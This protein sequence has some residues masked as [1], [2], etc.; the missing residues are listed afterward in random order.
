MQSFVSPEGS[1]PIE[2]WRKTECDQQGGLAFARA[3]AAEDTSQCGAEQSSDF[4]AHGCASCHGLDG[5]GGVVGPNLL[6]ITPDKIAENVRFGPTGMPVFDDLELTEEHVT[7]IT[8]Y[9]RQVALANPGAVPTPVPPPP[10]PTATPVATP[11][12]AAVATPTTAPPA[13]PADSEILEEG[14]LIYQETAGQQGCAY[15]HGTDARGV[16]LATE[17]APDIRGASRSMIRTALGGTL[18]MSDIKLTSS[19]INAVV[20]YLQFLAAEP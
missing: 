4:V 10:T 14:R 6:A 9:L 11:V 7:A 20:A 15:C 13:P 2:V 16:G 19:Q 18:D 3:E 12:V 5:T 1:A 8:E 17:S